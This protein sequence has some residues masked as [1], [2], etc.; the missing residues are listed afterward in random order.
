MANKKKAT[1][2]AQV[3]LTETL[4]TV[5]NTATNINKQ[6]ADTAAI[7]AKDLRASSI[8]M[9]ENAM[10]TVKETLDKATDTLSPKNIRKAFDSA[11]NYALKS[12]DEV[13][14]TSLAY[15]KKW[16]A[17][18]EKAMKGG[19]DLA[20]KQQE[21]VF[22]AMETVKEQLEESADRFKKLFK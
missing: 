9:R 3:D 20:A 15:T 19:L 6:L 1:K 16:Q 2:N 13:V 18:G 12:V 11:N 17:V 8:Q 22:E 7:V 14:D 21:I 5:R 10:G 4:E